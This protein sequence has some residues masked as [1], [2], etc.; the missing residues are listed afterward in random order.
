MTDPQHDPHTF[1][2]GDLVGTDGDP[3][4]VDPI[5]EEITDPAHPDYVEPA[6][7][8]TPVDEEDA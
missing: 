4:E 8:A 1:D 6:D 5:P 3:A 2:T 7:G